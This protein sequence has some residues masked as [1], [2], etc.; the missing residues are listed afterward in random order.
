MNQYIPLIILLVALS[1]TFSGLTIGMFSMSVNSLER[2]AKLGNIQAKRVLGVRKKGN[3]LLCTLLLGNVAVNSAISVC[4]SEVSSGVMAGV[5]ATGVIFVF[6]EVTPQA[7]F[8]R[9]ALYVGYHTTWLI[10]AF[11]FI[12]WP[13][14]KP[15][16]MALDFFLGKE[17]PERYDRNELRAVVAEHSLED[18]KSSPLD[19]DEKRIMLGAMR[20]S[21]KIVY[22][23]MT[24]ATSVFYLDEKIVANEM[25]LK[26]IL[27]EKYSRVPVTSGPRDNVVGILYVKDL[28]V[29]AQDSL[30]TVNMTIGELS[31]QENIIMVNENMHLDAALNHLIKNKSHMMFVYNEFNSL[32]GVVTMED[33]IEEV[34]GVE[35]LDESDSAADMCN[36]ASA[37]VSRKTIL[38]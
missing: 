21:E 5:I 29:Y 34:F 19:S 20:F 18:E 16:S 9:H 30:T 37:K 6:G 17:F 31:R 26:K 4:M 14:A 11:M 22:D 36:Q 13:I 27:D 32:I 8:S 12:M 35:I 2:K 38:V 10:R 25:V 7:V 3:F 15:L 33:I 1:A 24:P 28:A 23:V